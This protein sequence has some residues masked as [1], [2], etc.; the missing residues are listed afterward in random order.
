MG[1]IK[2]REGKKK[3]EEKGRKGGQSIKRAA[4]WDRG[5]L[6]KDRFWFRRVTRNNRYS[7]FIRLFDTLWRVR[8]SYPA[9]SRLR[10]SYLNRRLLLY[11]G[12]TKTTPVLPSYMQKT[13]D[14]WTN[15]WKTDRERE[16]GGNWKPSTFSRTRI[17]KILRIS[18]D[19]FVGENPRGTS[20]IRS[21]LIGKAGK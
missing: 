6:P 8:E 12:T 10:L 16:R 21:W 2:R 7:M 19:R 15:R 18:I 13:R 11:R 4:N 5:W 9:V 14:G 3:K 17:E 20:G 1:R